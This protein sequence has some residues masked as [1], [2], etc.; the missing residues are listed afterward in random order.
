[1]YHAAGGELGAHGG[2]GPLWSGR[3]PATGDYVVRVRATGGPTA[4]TLA[5]QIPRRVV[6]DREN[7]SASYAGAAPSRAPV[8]FIIKGEQGRTLEVVLR[9]EDRPSH[10]H[11]YGL[12]D[13][14]QLAPLADRRDRFAGRLPSTQD[15]V[16]S[17]VPWGEGARYELLM[18]VR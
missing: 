15:Y 3:L 10:L 13:G 2:S 12:D 16:V 14:I 7:P 8:D 9:S 17:V 4:Y 6:V 1:V 5:V 11:V 18:T